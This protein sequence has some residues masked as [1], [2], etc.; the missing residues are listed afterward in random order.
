MR[1]RNNARKEQNITDAKGQRLDLLKKVYR[2]PFDARPGGLSQS[3]I[4][5]ISQKNF[6]H[7]MHTLREPKGQP[8]PSIK[9][10]QLIWRYYQQRNQLNSASQVEPLSLLDFNMMKKH[11][12]FNSRGFGEP[13]RKAKHGPVFVSSNE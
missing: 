5:S 7:K 1:F 11:S 4:R 12:T 9:D 6:N 3:V 10:Q 8:E 2:L 13:S